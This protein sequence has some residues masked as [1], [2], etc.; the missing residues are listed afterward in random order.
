MRYRL[1]G[2]SFRCQVINRSCPTPRSTHGIRA[3]KIDANRRKESPCK[4]AKRDTDATTEYTIEI[5]L[6]LIVVTCR[7]SVSP[8]PNPKNHEAQSTPADEY[9]L[10]VAPVLFILKPSP[11]FLRT[12]CI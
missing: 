12:T 1:H 10:D 4:A 11:A 5:S 3:I 9:F 8:K 6:F 7:A 2:P